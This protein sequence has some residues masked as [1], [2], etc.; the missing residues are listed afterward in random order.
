MLNAVVVYY[1]L[2]WVIFFVCYIYAI[3][4]RSPF[5]L[6]GDG[7][8]FIGLYAP[9]DYALCKSRDYKFIYTQKIYALSEKNKQ[10][11]HELTRSIILLLLHEYISPP[12]FFQQ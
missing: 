3:N 5:L 10:G 1:L 6:V 2:L 7:A 11:T 4:A 8:F 9:V 12:N